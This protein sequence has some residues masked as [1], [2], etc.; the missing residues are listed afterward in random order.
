MERIRVE[1]ERVVNVGFDTLEKLRKLTRL[2]INHRIYEVEDLREVSNIWS[3]LGKLSSLTVT[4][5]D[6]IF[7]FTRDVVYVKYDV[8]EY[9][10]YPVKH[11]EMKLGIQHHP[12]QKPGHHNVRQHPATHWNAR[13]NQ[14]QSARRPRHF[15]PIGRMNH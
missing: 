4:C 5:Y 3:S 14:G 13:W 1:I 10:G 2:T 7:K 15:P 6:F 12:N 8:P 9:D 11:D